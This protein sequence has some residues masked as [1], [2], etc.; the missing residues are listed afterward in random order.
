MEPCRLQL[1]H[2]VPRFVLDKTSTRLTAHIEWSFEIEPAIGRLHVKA[3]SGKWAWD[4]K[5]TLL[6]DLTCRGPIVD[7]SLESV[8]GG[9]DVGYG[10]AADTF[11]SITPNELQKRWSPKT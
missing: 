1:D 9:L 7:G 8:R 4:S 5:D 3:Q 10:I 11:L 6:L 2:P